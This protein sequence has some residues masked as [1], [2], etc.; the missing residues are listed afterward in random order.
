MTRDCYGFNQGVLTQSQ[1]IDNE[2]DVYETQEKRV[3]LVKPGEY[4][5]ECF[6][7]AEQ[8]LNLVAG[9]LV[10]LWGTQLKRRD[11]G[12]VVVYCSD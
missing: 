12:V 1:R 5:R 3:H 8:P 6:Q 7:P 10:V 4:P 11:Y 9:V 2:S